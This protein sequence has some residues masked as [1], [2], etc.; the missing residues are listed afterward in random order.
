MYLN[1]E[2]VKNKNNIPNFDVTLIWSYD[3]KAFFENYERFISLQV[4]EKIFFLPTVLH[5]KAGRITV[6]KDVT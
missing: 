5:N 1:S 6:T 4:N 2:I 3:P